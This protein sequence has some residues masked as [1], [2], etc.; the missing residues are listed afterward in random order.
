M[1]LSGGH[2][3]SIP[4]SEVAGRPLDVSMLTYR[5]SCVCRVP[6]AVT[7][8]YGSVNGLPSHVEV[9]PS[10]AS[11]PQR[12]TLPIILGFAALLLTGVAV[13]GYASS[14]QGRQ[15]RLRSL[16]VMKKEGA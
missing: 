11:P 16:T 2:D 6:D 15:V 3:A 9:D 12:R 13:I 4:F 7:V 10:H 8:S 14:S 1:Q 5:T